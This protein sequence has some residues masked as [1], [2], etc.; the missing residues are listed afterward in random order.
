MHARLIQHAVELLSQQIWCWGRDILRPE[1]NWLLENGFDRAEP[2]ANLNECASIYSLPLPDSGCVMLRGFGIFYGDQRG[3]V[4][5]PRYE[6]RPRYTKYPT[7]KSQPW[8]PTD[9]PDLN[10]PKPSQ[11]K[12]CT[13][14]T[15]DLID[16]IRGYEV[17]VAHNLGNEYRKNTLIEWEDPKRSVI[18][19]ED[20]ANEWRL[21][22][23][24]IAQNSKVLV[25]SN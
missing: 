4:F 6:F 16:W 19:A 20:M 22:G 8:A 5:L 18:P 10:P 24:A 17:N 23:A 21:L 2:P 12:S 14:L 25:S 9:M 11:L 15:L 1:G 3:G 7:L 13:S